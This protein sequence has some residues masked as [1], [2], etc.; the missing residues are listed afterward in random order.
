MC[1]TGRGTWV[2][3]RE[4]GNV[5][6]REEVHVLHRE[7]YMG[8]QVKLC[9]W[10]GVCEQDNYESAKLRVVVESVVMLGSWQ[11]V[12][13]V[14]TFHFII[15]IYTQQGLCTQTTITI[16]N[17]Q[18]NIITSVILGVINSSSISY[19]EREEL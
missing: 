9:N 19:V 11:P 5:V 3:Y 8:V 18:T 10:N 16:T 6:Y 12:K 17:K 14:N 13:V 1:Y 2:I 4:E 7:G 15:I